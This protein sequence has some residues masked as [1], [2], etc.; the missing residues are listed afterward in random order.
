[1]LVALGEAGA[2][3]LRPDGTALAH[4]DVPAF[5]LVP[6]VHGDRALA[7]APR[8]ELLR[9]SRLDLSA[10][11]AEPWCEA[12]V[13]AFASSYDGNLWFVSEGHTALGVD[14]L[15]RDWRALWRVT[16]VGQRVLAVA[17][18]GAQLSLLAA[19]GEGRGEV[20]T[21]GLSGGPTL[22]SR[23]P[24]TD[25]DGFAHAALL[26]DGTLECGEG[27][28]LWNGWRVQLALVEGGHEARLAQQVTAVRARLAFEGPHPPGGRF[29]NRELVL[30]DGAGR[31]VRVEL[32]EGTVRR[33]RVL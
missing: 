6:S 9:V 1:M 18:E 7:L 19:E 21:Y 33:L 30:F 3:L 10:R 20:W 29:W 24:V 28:L 13:D 32:G 23:R 8:G 17:Q 25:A 22:R 11:R 2:R 15:A 5:R 27:L 4:F 31:L 26:A 14:A 16:Q 12:R